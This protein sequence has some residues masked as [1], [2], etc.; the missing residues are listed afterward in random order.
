MSGQ[1]GHFSNTPAGTGRSSRTSPGRSEPAVLPV[2]RLLRG[3]GAA[4][5]REGRAVSALGAD[6]GRPAQPGRTPVPGTAGRPL[7]APH[8]QASWVVRYDGC[9]E[10]QKTET[11]ISCSSM[12]DGDQYFTAEQMRARDYSTGVYNQFGDLK[13]TPRTG[14][15][16][17]SRYRRRPTCPGPSCARECA[18]GSRTTASR[19][20]W[21]AVTAWRPR[22]PAEPASRS[23][24]D[25]RSAPSRRRARSPVSPPAHMRVYA[26]R[27]CARRRWRCGKDDPEN[28]GR[29]PVSHAATASCRVRAPASNERPGHPG[30][31]LAQ[32][33]AHRADRSVARGGDLPVGG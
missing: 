9:K 24:R 23:G 21:C 18:M 1:L 6:R 8:P 20:G 14:S 11:K 12:D 16:P 33:T 25:T 2:S 19:S 27:Q 26:D 15:A 3:S 10:A 17:G 22:R 31:G 28:R 5:V 29:F 30:P 4:A 32:P 13:P 7:K